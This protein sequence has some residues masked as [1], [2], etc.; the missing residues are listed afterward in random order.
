MHLGFGKARERLGLREDG[1][2]LRVPVL[3]VL[4]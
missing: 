2:E 4:F 3:E 1:G